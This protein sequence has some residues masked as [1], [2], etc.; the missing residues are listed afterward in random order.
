[1]AAAA[2][3]TEVMA[4]QIADDN[5]DEDGE[6]DLWHSS[7]S[8][9]RYGAT[10]PPSSINGGGNSGVALERSARSPSPAVSLVIFWYASV[11][12]IQAQ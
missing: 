12:E 10:I 1:M 11:S 3:L 9:R 7:A 6:D 8:G 2:R 4:N 5:D